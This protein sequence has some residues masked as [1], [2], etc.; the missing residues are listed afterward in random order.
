[1]KLL[2]SFG[3]ACAF[4]FS[5]AAIAQERI[6]IGQTVVENGFIDI[7]TVNFETRLALATMLG[8]DRGRLEADIPDT[9]TGDA[10]KDKRNKAEFIDRVLGY[11]DQYK[12]VQEKFG[13][14]RINLD[15]R[16]LKAEMPDLDN[17][18]TVFVGADLYQAYTQ[19]V[20][21]LPNYVVMSR[22]GVD[23][24]TDGYIPVSRIYFGYPH[25]VYN[26]KFER[27]YV[28]DNELCGQ[29]RDATYSKLVPNGSV[30][31]EWSNYLYYV[32]IDLD[33]GEKMFNMFS[34]EGVYADTK[35]VINAI[36]REP[37]VDLVCNLE[38]LTFKNKAEN[39]IYQVIWNG[40]DYED[41]WGSIN[42]TPQN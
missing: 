2:V 35:C 5:P 39:L 32:F 22:S 17:Q 13:G 38:T 3:V 40:S 28:G 25:P 34:S 26:P 36:T 18:G 41:K 6:I 12:I 19:K 24:A 29:S 20:C 23:L 15:D 21:G 11:A 8:M 33:L 4:F 10:F 42:P 30:G 7:S 31:L 14:I 16:A 37:E 27:V 9:E 1:M